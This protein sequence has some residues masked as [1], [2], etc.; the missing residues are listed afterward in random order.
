[1]HLKLPVVLLS[2][3][4]LAAPG[5]M[6]YGKE[7]GP[8]DKAKGKNKTEQKADHRDDRDRRDGDHRGGDHDGDGKV[9]IC[10]IPPGNSSARH[11]ISV[12][13]AAWSAH[14]AHGDHRG[15][16]GPSGSPH[17][18][19]TFD[20]LDLNDDG[21]LTFEE[22]GRGDRTLFDRLDRNDNNL[23]SRREFTRR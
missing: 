13:E 6:A 7:K 21:A 4:A 8:K 12:G 14:Q 1:M 22:W 18:R 11:T 20:D 2:A 9:T 17:P 5:A 3:F 23:L 16:C 10:H 15:A 19:R